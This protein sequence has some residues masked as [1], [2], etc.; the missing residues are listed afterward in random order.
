[1]ANASDQSKKLVES[2]IDSML[3][4]NLSAQDAVSK[5]LTPSASTEGKEDD[6]VTFKEGEEV[7]CPACGSANMTEGF[8]ESESGQKL[9][10]YK[11]EDCGCG[12]VEAETDSKEDGEDLKE[13]ELD[14]NDPRC[15]S[16]G[17]DNLDHEMIESEDG[18]EHMVITC[19]KCNTR[20][21]VAD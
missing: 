18:E 15:P 21:V 19:G 11:C 14:E 8:V 6:L 13:A 5:I 12:L 1:M 20:M 2:M 4:G 7:V 17:S 10:A 9:A 3:K 16:C